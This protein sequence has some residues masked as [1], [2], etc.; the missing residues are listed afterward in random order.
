MP[1]YLSEL[2]M[3]NGNEENPAFPST[4]LIVWDDSK[5]KKIGLIIMK[6]KIIDFR[7]SK[8]LIYV[9]LPKKILIF[10]L[11]TLLYIGILEDF[12]YTNNQ[13]SFSLEKTPNLIAYV[14]N[15]NKA[16]IKIHKCKLN[17]IIIF[18]FLDFYF[19]YPNSNANEEI[20]TNNKEQLNLANSL[21]NSMKSKSQIVII[22]NFSNIQAIQISKNVRKKIFL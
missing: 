11:S 10:E 18:K 15:S 8:S 1:F 13:L 16:I 2:V 9:I 17:L 5:K 20:L 6:E 4:Q 22:T 7:I 3:F 21:D 14:S 19:N 12:S